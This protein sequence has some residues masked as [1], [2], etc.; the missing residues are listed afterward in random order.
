M[1]SVSYN[2]AMG[3]RQMLRV[4]RLPATGSSRSVLSFESKCSISAVTQTV[5]LWTLDLGNASSVSQPTP[6]GRVRWNWRSKS[7]SVD[8]VHR[9]WATLVLFLAVPFTIFNLNGTALAQDQEQVLQSLLTDAA[10]AQARGDFSAAAESYRKATELEPAVPEFWANLGLMYY[11]LGRSAEA[12]Q[13]F[14][15]AIRLNAS[16]YVPQLF[17]GI[18]YLKTQKPN[19]ALPLLEAATRLNAKDP[20]AELSLGKAYAMVDRDDR[21]VEA[22]WRA[23]RL[24]PNDGD[25]WLGLGTAYLQQ[26][27]NDARLMTSTY[28][29]SPFAGLRAG[30]T[31]AEEGKLVDAENAYKSAIASSSTAPCAHAEFGITLLREKKIAD[32]REQF[33]LDARTGSHCGLNPLGIAVAEAA[34]GHSNAALKMLV[35][36]TANDP[37]FLQSNLYLFRDALSADQAKSLAELARE[38]EG[39]GD[40]AI[41]LGSAVEQAFLSDTSPATGIDEVRASQTS[42]AK[43]PTDADSLYATGKY[44]TCDQVLKPALETLDSAQL[45]LLASCSFYAGDFLTTS[46]AA[47]RQKAN[48]ET[49]ARGLYWETKADQKLAIASL[50]RAGEIDPNSPRMHV[51]AGDVFRQKRRWSEAEAEYRKALA[52][53]PTSRGARLSLAIVLFTEL[54]TDE[55]LQITKSLLAEVPDDPE[56]NLLA[57]E[58]LVQGHQFDQAE[59]YLSKCNGLDPD[60]IPRLHVLFGQVYAATNRISAAISEYKLGLASDE[61]GSIHYQLARLYEKSGDKDAAEEEIRISQQL[62]KRWDDQA[63]T[64][65]EQLPTDTTRQ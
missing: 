41:D 39:A 50:S 56:A 9:K 59:P 2:N 58:I 48:R 16:L 46:K 62:R 34:E 1:K 28:N 25:A 52:I 35:S 14:K 45:Q 24:S 29:Q 4:I 21:A 65:I 51:L 18:E 5:A 33:E 53:D 23:T 36:I 13:S 61:D 55:A 38:Q 3:F 27:D 31:Y 42:R 54:K 26:V 11:E 8:S 15:E 12:I 64:V 6:E 10:G 19:A 7:V 40:L 20:L 37:G 60:L 57:G 49:L 22:F 32:A 44:S 47:E 63:H 17:L 30:E 43:L